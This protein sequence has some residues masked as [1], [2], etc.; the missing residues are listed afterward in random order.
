MVILLLFQQVYSQDWP[1][2]SD[3]RSRSSSLSKSRPASSGSTVNWAG[4][5]STSEPAYAMYGSSRSLPAYGHGSSSKPKLPFK[6]GK[7]GIKKA[8]SYS[9]GPWPVYM[10]E[11]VLSQVRYVPQWC[12]IWWVCQCNC[13]MCF[14]VIVMYVVLVSGIFPM[15]SCLPGKTFEKK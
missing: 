4:G 13:W 12:D 1:R 15:N 8:E 14:I 2:M 9:S 5:I 10:D 6:I 7:G 11:K 3:S